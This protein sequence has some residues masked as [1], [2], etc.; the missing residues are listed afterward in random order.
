[1]IVD[2]FGETDLYHHYSLGLSARQWIVKR[3]G[4]AVMLITG[5]FGLLPCAPHCLAL[6][7]VLRGL[8]VSRAAALTMY[9]GGA[10]RYHTPLTAVSGPPLT[11]QKVAEPSQEQID[12]LHADYI[13]ALL[14]LFDAHK[15]KHGYGAAKLEIL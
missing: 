8:S 13:R 6:S 9:L 3:F 11:V 4:A 10:P 14:T 5:S 1:M 2:V 12:A 7:N 15:A